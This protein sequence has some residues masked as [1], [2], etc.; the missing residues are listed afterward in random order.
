MESSTP[1]GC[2]VS[3]SAFKIL[4]FLRIVKDY[5]KKGLKKKRQKKKEK[6]K[7]INKKTLTQ[8]RYFSYDWTSTI[9]LFTQHTLQM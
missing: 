3:V 6:K 5:H 8:E 2:L 4:V 9:V 1:P 7:E